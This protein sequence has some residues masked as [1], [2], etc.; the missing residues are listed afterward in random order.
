MRSVRSRSNTRPSASATSRPSTVP[1]S[2]PYR[3]KRV[4]PALVLTLPPIWHF[5]LAPRSSGIVRPR[6]FAALSRSSSVTPASA[7]TTPALRSTETTARIKRRLTITSSCTGTPPPTKPVFPP[8]GTTAKRRSLQCF[9]TRDTSAVVLGR[10]R[11][12]DRP[13]YFFIQS[14]FAVA[15]E[16]ASRRTL[17]TEDEEEDVL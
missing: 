8:W 14:S 16:P 7:T 9:S 13:R 10:S 1:R 2:E 17:R 3:T 5:P 11:T 12:V 4:P 6:A 15:S